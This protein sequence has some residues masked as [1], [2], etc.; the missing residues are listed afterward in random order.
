MSWLDSLGSLSDTV[1]GKILQSFALPGLRNWHNIWSPDDSYKFS[2]IADYLKNKV[3]GSSSGDVSNNISFGSPDTSVT[4]PSS[5][6]VTN[7]LPSDSSG[8]SV[9]SPTDYNFGEY[10]EGLLSSV[11]AEAEITRQY[12]SAEAALQREWASKENQLNRDWQTSMSN[13]AYQRAV[14][15]LKAA[16]LN[17]ILAAT[18]SSSTPTGVVSS[19]SSASS[20]IGNGDTMSSLLNAIANLASSVADFLPNFNFN[21]KEK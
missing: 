11:G 3:G 20:V 4:S 9:S 21:Y 2:S 6:E 10:L 17:P 15:D 8:S 1:I 14:S 13:S 19:G 5:G 18:G 16:G 7:N 12:N